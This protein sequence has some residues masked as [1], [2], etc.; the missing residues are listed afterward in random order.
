MKNQKEL[1]NIF[2]EITDK[3]DMQKL[4]DELFTEKEK[5]DFALRWLL[6]QELMNKIPQRDIAAKYHI[7]L[8]KITRGAKVL[9]TK[10]SICRKILGDKG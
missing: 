2:S 9:K 7:S 6:M 8:C 10:G 3:K 5:K 4:F 1:I